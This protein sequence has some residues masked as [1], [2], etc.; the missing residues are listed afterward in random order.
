MLPVVNRVKPSA[1]WTRLAQHRIRL[2]VVGPYSDQ[3]ATSPSMTSIWPNR[4]AQ[5][6]TVSSGLCSTATLVTTT[7][8]SDAASGGCDAT[9]AEIARHP[10]RLDNGQAY[11]APRDQPVLLLSP[12]HPD[13]FLLRIY[14]D[15]ATLANDATAIA[16]SD[17]FEA[18]PGHPLRYA[19]LTDP[20][21]ALQF[22]RPTETMLVWCAADNGAD[23][24]H[25]PTLQTIARITGRR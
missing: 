22:Y 13:L 12:N 7:G 9:A 5:S 4:H 17:A 1:L 11:G 14:R 6:G 23:P 18:V 16:T 15:S 3:I 10:K 20:G 24:E 19:S 25:Q 8:A 2:D 21:C